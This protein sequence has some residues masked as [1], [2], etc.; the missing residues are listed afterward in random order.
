MR[1]ILGAAVMAWT[2]FAATPEDAA[3]LAAKALAAY[4]HNQAQETHWNWIA[5]ETR[6][7]ANKSGEVL[8]TFPSVTAESTIRSNG[9]RCNAVV[10]WG[11]GRKPYLA[12]ADADA[13][14]QAMDSF[15]PPFQVSALLEGAHATVVER[16]PAGIT[17]AVVPDK[18]R[19]KSQDYAVRCAASIRAT[20]RLDP[21]TFFPMYLEG[22][23]VEQGC[24][25]Q[26]QPI[27]QYG[28]RNSGPVKSNFR[29]GATFRIQFALQ[30]DKFGH[31]EHSFWIAVDQHYV[32][33]WN[34]ESVLL[35]YWGR[36][37]QVAAGDAAHHL[38]KDVKTTA[39]EFGGES[40]LRFDTGQL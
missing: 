1:V 24:D 16:A 29:K 30:K 27:L 11:D 37:V 21:G 40:T 8:Q 19:L 35:Y 14:C 20:F 38:I 2:G 26:F 13:R 7:I 17:L 36:Q 32:Q 22:E 6:A 10:A 31:P 39:K 9:R 25:N 4:V 34:S 33:P 15:R 12:G 3:P 18:S 5:V 23:V 28:A